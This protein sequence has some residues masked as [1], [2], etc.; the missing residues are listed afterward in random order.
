MSMAK[1][2]RDAGWVGG[3]NYFE[4]APGRRYYWI[5]NSRTHRNE[6]FWLKDDEM[7]PINIV[8]RLPPADRERLRS[9]V[10]PRQWP[11]DPSSPAS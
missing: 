8:H 7:V 11:E 4:S 2:C 10:P 6:E 1:M 9:Q 5:R 3:K